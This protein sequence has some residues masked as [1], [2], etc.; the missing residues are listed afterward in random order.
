MALVSAMKA[1]L[2]TFAVALLVPTFAMGAALDIRMSQRNSSNTA[3]M[4]VVFAKQ[5]SSLIGT[6][7]TGI[8]S[9]VA[10]GSGLDLTSGVLTATGGGGGAPTT[11]TYITQTP[12]GSLDNEQALSLLSSGIMRVATTT[13]AVTSLGDPTTLGL[14]FMFLANPS[15]IRFPRINADNTVDAISDSDFRTAIGAGTGSGNVTNNATLTTGRLLLGGGTTV[16]GITGAATNGQLYIGNSTNGNMQLATLTAGDN[17]SITN[18]P[19]G[20]TINSTAS[21]SGNVTNNATLTANNIVLGG[22]TTVVGT[23]TMSWNATNSTITIGTAGTGNIIA[24]VITANTLSLGTLNITDLSVSGNIVSASAVD[25]S[26]FIG[27]NTGDRYQPGV[28]TAGDNITITN[29][30]GTIM[31]NA[32]SGGGASDFLSN[33]T[34]SEI[35]VTT[36]ATATID[37]MHVCTGTTSNY[38]VTLPAVSGN[39]G[40]LIG[41]RMAATMNKVVTIDGAASETI[42]GELSRLML[43]NETAVLLCDGATW[44]KLSGKT[45]PAS[46]K[47]LKAS[48]TTV[49]DEVNTEISVGEVVQDSTGLMADV[50]GTRIVIVRTG[51]YNLVARLT[52]DS[53]SIVAAQI[54]IYKNAGGGGEALIDNIGT[55][56]PVA[57]GAQLY[58]ANVVL[59]SGDYIE[60]F[61]YHNE[62][63]GSS[64]VFYGASGD[65]SSS[66]SVSEVVT[67]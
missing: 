8:P 54:R 62:P 33:L 21:G 1:F 7:S 60:L 39:S 24:N 4:D 63:G 45:I 28:L 43:A 20:I 32:T 52:A 35:S 59:S 37:R 48:N 66:I 12:N 22:G 19:G 30:P 65:L 15:A 10:I 16:V 42:D 53:I 17:I 58:A 31:I 61:A 27:N 23:S 41:L 26:L 36:T 40:R 38:T 55:T 67:W 3:W 25:G 18:S 9:I 49:S 6:N 64:R 11:A 50:A 13:G 29:G 57:G 51:Q 5:N 34:A 44:T 47:M 2:R 56:L 14:S 46:A